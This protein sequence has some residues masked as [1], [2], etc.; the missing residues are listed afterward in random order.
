LARIGLINSINAA[1]VDIDSGRKGFATKGKA[2]E[3]RISYEDGIALAMSAFKEA[4]ATADPETII[5]SKYTFLIPFLFINCE[6]DNS[7]EINNGNITGNTTKIY[8][9]NYGYDVAYR[10][11]GNKI[12]SGSYVYDVAYRIER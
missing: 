7:N 1:A 2:E 10:I 4:Q 12:Y 11:D 6:I 9:D 3:G 8:S 5:L